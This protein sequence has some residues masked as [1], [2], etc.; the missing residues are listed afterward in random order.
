MAE[1]EQDDLHV[2]IHDSFPL[3]AFSPSSLQIS[4]IYV[5]KHPLVSWLWWCVPE[6]SACGRLRQDITSSRAARTLI[7]TVSQKQSKPLQKPVLL[8]SAGWVFP[9]VFLFWF[10]GGCFLLLLLLAVSFQVFSN[11]SGTSICHMGEGDLTWLWGGSG[12]EDEI[13]FYCVD[14][15][16]DSILPGPA[17]S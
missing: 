4:K 5:I 17:V 6:I 14:L 10:W 12:C 2:L 13:Q 7:N 11:P 16:I 3:S 1:S 9:R 8:G 15:E